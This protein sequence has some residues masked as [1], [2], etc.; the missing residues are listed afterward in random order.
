[1]SHRFAIAALG[2]VCATLS[3]T[4]TGCVG[5]HAGVDL[6]V[7]GVPIPVSPYF[8][9]KQEDKFWNHERYERVPILGPLV[10]GAPTEALDPPSDDEVMR[11][12]ER[13]NPIQGGL[14]FLH[15]FQRNNVRIVKDKIADYVDPPRVVPL[16]GP[17]QLHHC[18]YKCTIYYTEVTRVGWPIPHTLVD[19]DAQEVIYIDHNHFHMVGNINPGPSSNY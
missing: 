9:K 19:E 15:E 4:S 18:H 10:P 13:A 6:G 7:F 3:V 2:I 14:P 16:I 5:L 12:W 17:V 11:A 8:Q 1:M